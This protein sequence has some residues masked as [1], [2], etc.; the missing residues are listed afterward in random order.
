MV[1]GCIVYTERAGLD[2][3]SFTWHQPYNKQT[4]LYVQHF[5]GDSKRAIES[6]SHSFRITC[7]ISAVSLLENGQQRYIKAII[8]L[9]KKSSLT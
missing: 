7:S 9:S 2:S 8:N 4:A 3:S 5:G 6:Y 1:H